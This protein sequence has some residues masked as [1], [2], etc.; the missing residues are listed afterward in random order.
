MRMQIFVVLELFKDCFLVSVV[1]YLEVLLSSISRRELNWHQKNTRVYKSSDLPL[2]GRLQEALRRTELA[3]ETQFLRCHIIHPV[4]VP[5]RT[6]D[7][8]KNGQLELEERWHEQVS[9]C[10]VFYIPPPLGAAFLLVNMESKRLR[11]S[12]RRNSLE[13]ESN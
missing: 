4:P 7:T 6:S 2:S 1:K 10:T 5:R 9:L 3:L 12:S 13:V 11:Q 8:L